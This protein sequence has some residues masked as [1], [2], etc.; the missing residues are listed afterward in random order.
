MD[1][2]YDDFKYWTWNFSNKFDF[3]IVYV[4]KVEIIIVTLKTLFI[5]NNFFFSNFWSQ[6]FGN[7]FLFV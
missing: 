2:V 7:L 4:F 1:K 5:K 6:F 3:G